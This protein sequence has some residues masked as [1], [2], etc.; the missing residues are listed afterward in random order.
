MRIKYANEAET[1]LELFQAVSVF[2]FSFY[3]QCATGFRRCSKTP[4]R[5]ADTRES[6]QKS[7]TVT[8]TLY[9]LIN[10]KIHDGKVTTLSCLAICR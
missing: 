1:S 2:C 5:S 3:S 7:F 6:S 4:Y 9:R 8:W 10:N